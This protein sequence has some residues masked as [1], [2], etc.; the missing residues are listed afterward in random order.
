[1]DRMKMKWVVMGLIFFSGFGMA[2]TN[3]PPTPVLV[4]CAMREGTTLMDITYRINDPDN[5][6]VSAWP[7]AFL[8]GTRSFAKVIR[9]TTFVEGTEN[10]FGTNVLANTNYQLVWNVGADLNIDLGQ[11]KFQMIC[12]D[13]RGLLPFDWL[14]IPSTS[15]TSAMTISKNSPT[16]TQVLSA[17]FYQYAMKDGGLSLSNGVLYGSSTSGVFK[18][19]ELV[20]GETLDS[21]AAP[22]IIKRMGLQPALP[23]DVHFAIAARAGIT[24]ATG[25]W[26]AKNQPYNGVSN[27]IVGVGYNDYGVRSVPA[28]LLNLKM[29]SGGY[30]H[31]MALTSDGKVVSWGWNFFGECDL[32]AG[33][34]SVTAVAAGG[35]F[36]LALKSDGKVV[37]WGNND[38]GQCTIPAGLSNV[39][40]IG[41]GY[42]H[43]VALKSD[44]KV[45]AW[46][47]QNIYGQL[48]VPIG[49]S[50]V[51]AIAVGGT[52]SLAL[53][54]DGTVVAWGTGGSGQ[55]DV[56]EGLSDVI[57]IAAG[58]KHSMAL[59]SDG[60]VVLWGNNDY[61]QSILPEGLSNVTAIAAGGDHSL[62][63]KNDG[64]VV[65][66]GRND[67]GQCNIP[68]GINPVISIE[69]GNL[70]TLL[71]VKEP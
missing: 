7:L 34:S 70:F 29:I 64:T 26:Y 44:G 9:P 39:T 69:G 52:H 67:N 31:T 45:V 53:K 14:A 41:A 25:V 59:K 60:S 43:S 28:G 12:K 10:N 56:P 18:G 65:A 23:N 37:G 20:R 32:P 3:T 68:T 19:V 62:A 35:E 71:T 27:L 66:W 2:T 40:A 36:S 30:L 58:D 63:L 49:L 8:D 24:S 11:L 21:Y 1:M 22:Y 4:S 61:G 46:G 5:T 48:N 47:G 15:S 16:D 50:N 13:S 51:T 54:S 57:A 42:F 38:V 17:L 55:L 33:L 6:V